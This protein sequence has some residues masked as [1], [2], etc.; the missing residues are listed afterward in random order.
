MTVADYLLEHQ[1][2]AEAQLMEF[3]RIPSVSTDPAHS[4][5]V[6]RCAQWL[7]QHLR[8]IGDYGRHLQ[9]LDPFIGS[10]P[11]ASV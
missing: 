3:L 9:Q 11:L 10:L 5:D 7:A 1:A 6:E 8:S 4:G 2:R